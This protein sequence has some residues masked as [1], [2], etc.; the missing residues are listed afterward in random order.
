MPL[1][2]LEG[3]TNQGN[4][5]CAEGQL[6]NRK[7]LD[8]ANSTNREQD[9]TSLSGMGTGRKKGIKSVFY[10]ILVFRHIIFKISEKGK[11]AQG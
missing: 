3:K 9:K 2:L 5:L 10:L 8:Q 11:E 1:I 7:G 6:D 4:S